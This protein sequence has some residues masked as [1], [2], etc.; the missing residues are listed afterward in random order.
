MACYLI[1]LLCNASLSSFG[2]WSRKA[3]RKKQ[4]PVA[5]QGSGKGCLEGTDLKNYTS[6]SKGENR[7]GGVAQTRLKGEQQD[8]WTQL[9]WA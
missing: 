6:G 9:G 2:E 8:W 4:P 5:G 3:S 1:C 7:W